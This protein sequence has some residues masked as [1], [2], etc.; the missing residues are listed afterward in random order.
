MPF[1]SARD[2]VY[3]IQQ[4]VTDVLMTPG[5]RLVFHALDIKPDEIVQVFKEQ[6]ELA[7][8]EPKTPAML[9]SEQIVDRVAE[10]LFKTLDT[11]K[12]R[13]IALKEGGSDHVQTMNMLQSRIGDW[14]MK[15]GLFTESKGPETKAPS[16][17]SWVGE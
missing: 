10:V 12:A 13:L 5:N 6:L 11:Y 9:N 14:F 7:L 1:S 4:F 15:N 16:D 8:E 3:A 17:E 2:F